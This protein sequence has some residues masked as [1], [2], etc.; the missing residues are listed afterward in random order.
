MNK[1]LILTIL[2]FTSCSSKRQYNF[3][4]L[5]K[6]STEITTTDLA[7]D[8]FEK[9][10]NEKYGDSLL[11]Y[12]SSNGNFRRVHLNSAEVGADSQFYFADK[13]KLYFTNKNSSQIDSLNT[14]EN[15]LKLIS[16]GKI[17]ELIIMGLVCE[18][19]EF[20]T[21]SQYDQNV[22][23]IIVSMQKVQKLTLIYIL[24]TMTFT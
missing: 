6:F 13:A 15:S 21:K 10:L 1:I 8:G 24:T 3:E 11:M 17:D 4:G 7:P 20:K 23:L 12:Y 16:K 2:I 5:I 18:C 14:K 9:Q 22:T 19:Y